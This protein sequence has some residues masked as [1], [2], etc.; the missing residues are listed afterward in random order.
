ML[1]QLQLPPAS[2]WLADGV[3]SF[4]SFIFSTLFDFPVVAA[5]S[6][7]ISDIIVLNGQ[8]FELE[9]PARSVDGWD[10]QLPVQVMSFPLQSSL[11]LFLIVSACGCATALKM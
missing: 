8:A 9:N 2:C 11:N 4:L 6:C 7:R 1:A 3:P 5:G 10:V